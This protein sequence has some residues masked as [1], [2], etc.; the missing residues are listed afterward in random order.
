MVLG[1]KSNTSEGLTSHGPWCTKCSK[2]HLSTWQ[3]TIGWIAS[4]HSPTPKI[5]LKLWNCSFLLEVQKKIKGRKAKLH[6]SLPCLNPLRTYA[7]V[8]NLAEPRFT[9]MEMGIETALLCPLWSTEKSHEELSPMSSVKQ[10]QK[11]QSYV[12][13]RFQ[14][15]VSMEIFSPTL[16]P[17][18]IMTI[19]YSDD[20]SRFQARVSMMLKYLI[21][22]VR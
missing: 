10:A 4:L 20:K 16:I 11:G 2:H 15:Q 5:I 12:T 14:F 21:I 3:L 18:C 17:L 13:L 22:H 19:I 1:R 6:K 8:N 9:W 7:W